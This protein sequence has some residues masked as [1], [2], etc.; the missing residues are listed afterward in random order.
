MIPTPPNQAVEA[1]PLRSVPHLERSPEKRLACSQKK[2][3]SQDRGASDVKMRDGL[4]LKMG[5]ASNRCIWL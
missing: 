3:H 1:T 5:K 4:T 2:P